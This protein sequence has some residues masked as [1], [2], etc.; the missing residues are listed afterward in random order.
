[1][2][3]DTYSGRLMTICHRYAGDRHEAEDMLQESFI[4]I[5]LNIH[6]FRGEGSF[7][8]WLR[9]ITVTTALRM[10]KKKKIQ[11]KEMN[12]HELLIAGDDKDALS[13]LSEDELL[14]LIK[15][16][17]SGYRIVFNLYVMEGYSH[18]EIGNMLGV[19]TV[20]SR[21]QLAKARKQLQKQIL[22]HKQIMH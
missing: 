14:S 7:E 1:M 9:R 4:K 22:L 8:G 12:H 5:F 18:E 2:L 16:L 11:F 17:P 3:F 15:N 6:Q 19:E 20:T 21:T 13:N 10:L